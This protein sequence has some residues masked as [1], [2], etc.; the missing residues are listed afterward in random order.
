MGARA[1]CAAGQGRLPPILVQGT[2]QGTNSLRRCPCGRHWQP[3]AGKWLGFKLE[4]IVRAARVLGPPQAPSAGQES[5]ID[6]RFFP[7]SAICRT[8]PQYGP[9]VRCS[10]EKRKGVYFNLSSSP[11]H[12]AARRCSLPASVISASLSRGERRVQ[13]PGR[14]GN[15]ALDAR[16]GGPDGSCS[17][18]GRLG[19]EQAVLPQRVP[20]GRQAVNWHR[21]G[22]SR[23]CE[24]QTRTGTAAARP[25]S[26]L[27][28]RRRL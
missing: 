12:R 3:G 2:T 5:R 23:I 17:S 28:A 11:R 19:P 1:S 20:P 25:G 9:A 21:R 14:P 10:E 26:R 27:A 6:V 13:R 24:P 18:Q 8:R 22:P 4:F 16:S 7:D 15:E